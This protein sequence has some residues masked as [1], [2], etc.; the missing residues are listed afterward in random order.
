MPE[1]ETRSIADVISVMKKSSETRVNAVT[2]S[3]IRWSGL[4]RSR[5]TSIL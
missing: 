2:S 4:S 5:S 1:K 3:Q